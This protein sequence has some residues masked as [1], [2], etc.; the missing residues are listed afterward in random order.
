MHRLIL[1]DIDGTLLSADG[2]GKRAF[3]AA[4][5]DVFG[6]IDEPPAY[7]FAG[8]TD[9]QI[10]R[11]L[12]TA[13]RFSPAQ[14]DAGLPGV[15]RRYTAYLESE[16]RGVEVC[17]L[18]GVLPLLERIEAA[19][20][21]TVLGL[22]TGNVREGAWIKLR[23][24]GIDPGRFRVGAYG[25]DHHERPEL[26]AVAVARAEALTRHRYTGKEIVIIGDTP[27]D[28]SCGAHLGVRTIAVATGVYS[29]EELCA[30]GPDHLFPDLGEVDR[31]WEAIHAS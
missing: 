20:E 17:P 8:R 12:L 6:P 23:A 19:G 31:V 13:A 24:A 14:V 16:I 11:E 18:P 22:L 4:I 28:V 1:F 10:A 26:P 3:H 2:A 25:S 27:R 21:P 5:R 29:L 30:C 15:F 7:T 9:P